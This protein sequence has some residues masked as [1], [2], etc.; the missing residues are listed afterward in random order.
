MIETDTLN[1]AGESETTSGSGKRF[2]D[3][4]I[5]TQSLPKFSGKRILSMVGEIKGESESANEIN[6]F[7][8]IDILPR[9]EQSNQP[10]EVV[11]RN[12][13]L[14]GALMGHLGAARKILEKDASK[15][16]QQIH[17]KTVVTEKNQVESQRLL[18]LHNKIRSAEKDMVSNIFVTKMN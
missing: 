10:A 8:G 16:D 12:K 2:R 9:P 4:D 5:S 13:R 15:I 3:V 17:A 6:S 11:S 14:F 7:D 18:A 1:N